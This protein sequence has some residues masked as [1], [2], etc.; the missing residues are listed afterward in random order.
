MACC[1]L[2]VASSGRPPLSRRELE[3]TEADPSRR[4][5][6]KIS[7]ESVLKSWLASLST[8]SRAVGHSHIRSLIRFLKKSLAW[9]VSREPYRKMAWYALPP[10]SRREYVMYQALAESTYWRFFT[11]PIMPVNLGGIFS[12]G[13][14]C[15]CSCT[16]RLSARAAASPEGPFGP[17]YGCES[18]ARLG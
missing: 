4:G 6:L 16:L 10:A 14:W 1:T 15:S 18:A 3:T 12:S 17:G 8:C 9:V 2:A 13:L 11:A 5:V 7:A